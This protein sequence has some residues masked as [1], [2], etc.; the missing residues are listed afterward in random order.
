MKRVARALLG[1]LALACTLAA[2]GPPEPVVII[3]PGDDSG[4]KR[5][6]RVAMTQQITLPDNFVMR[7]DEFAAVTVDHQRSAL[8]VGSREGTL[9]ALDHDSGEVLWEKALGGAVS[10]RPT[11]TARPGEDENEASLLLVGT[12]NG[13]LVAIDLAAPTEEPLW[14]YQTDGKIRNEAVVAE[15]V[16]YVVNSRDQVFALDLRTGTWRWQYEQPL[17]TA[18]TISGRAGLTFVPSSAEQVDEPGILYTGFDN[19]KV[20]AL[21]AGSG[22]ALW[23]ASVAPAQGGDFVDCDSTPLL[24]EGAG[25]LIV[26]GQSTGV[27]ALSLADGET[28]WSFPTRGVATVVRSRGNDL[29]GASSLEGVFALDRQGQMLW[30]TRVDPGVL[31]TPQVVGD[32][33]YV[34][35]SESGLL[36]FDTETGEFLARIDP[37]SGMSSV[38]VFDP[39]SSRFYAT[40][41]RGLLLALEIEQFDPNAEPVMLSR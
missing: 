28:Q 4:A 38:P 6:F 26:A 29:V 11:I 41:N 24:D 33:V 5:L 2:C 17:Q 36:A 23:L 35:H 15:G 27:H 13:E 21:G 37:G 7:P 14:R 12:D 40:T 32:T 8:Y 9:L 10:S 31:S 22:E 39:I 16:A 20:V 30:R 18:F 3:H 25:Q 19:G 34:T 1:S